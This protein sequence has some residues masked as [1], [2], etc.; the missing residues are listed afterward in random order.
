LYDEV[1]RL[2]NSGVSIHQITRTLETSRATIRK[3][4]RA[5]QCPT[6]S[7]RRTPINSMGRF[8]EHLRGRWNEGEHNALVLHSELRALGYRGG[9]RSVQRHVAA[10]VTTKARARRGRRSVGDSARPAPAR[11]PSP[12]QAKWWLTLPAE[13]LTSAQQDFVAAVI[14]KSPV[15]A[16]ATRLSKDFAAV[17]QSR[18][19]TRLDDW[20]VA[21]EGSTSSEFRELAAS[22]RRDMAAVQAAVTLSW[23]NG[24]TEGQVNKI[25]MFKRQ[26]FGRAKVDLLRARL[27][28]AA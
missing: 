20:L 28:N 7:P 2:A 8:D 19:S 24:Q 17:L 25:K 1:H 9:V 11:P 16:E 27:L 14:A 5:K 3:Y 12:K 18:T 13:R 4:L 6:R 21:A 26:M 15:I 10:W 23:S 22:L